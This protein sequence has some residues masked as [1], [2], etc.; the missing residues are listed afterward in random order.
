MVMRPFVFSN[1]NSAPG[2]TS[3]VR[4]LGLEVSI[5][6]RFIC[7]AYGACQP[8]SNVLAR[9]P[10]DARADTLVL[11]A[12]YDSV[13]AGPGASDDGIGVAALVEVARAIR[14]ERFRNPILFLI[15]DGEELGL[16]G[17]EAFVADA[18]LSRNAATVIN[19]DNRGPSG[20]TYLFETSRNNR[21]LL[22]I[23]ARA[24]PWPAPSSP[25]ST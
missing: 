13:G 23:V 15:T 10:G 24:L 14:N 22:P 1:A 3:N 17:A 11:A 4:S 8:V 25:S 21:W 5:Q 19:V 2:R 20:R 7:N 16:L 6:Q 12:H 9:M 18:N